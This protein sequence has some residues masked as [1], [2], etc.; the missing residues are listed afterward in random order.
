MCVQQLSR[1]CWTT[2]EAPRKPLASEEKKNLHNEND[3]VVRWMKENEVEVKAMQFCSFLQ[4]LGTGNMEMRWEMFLM[5]LS[6]FQI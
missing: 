1:S 2:V 4:S 5:L 6:N 3:W